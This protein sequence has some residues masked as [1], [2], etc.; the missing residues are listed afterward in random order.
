MKKTE[1]VIN[2]NFEQPWKKIV[3]LFKS[4]FRT[5]SNIC[6]AAFLG[7]ELTVKS[8]QLFSKKS[9]IGD[10]RLGSTYT[11]SVNHQRTFRESGPRTCRKSGPY[12][13]IHC[14]GQK[15]LDD[16][17]EVA[18]FKYDNNLLNLKPKI[19]PTRHFWFQIW[20]FFVFHKTLLN[21]I[22]KGAEYACVC[23]THYVP[24]YLNLPK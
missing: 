3:I 23:V 8:C 1:K 2:F 10:F 5:Q 20:N 7:K 22:Y 18:D 15:H 6:N 17:L 19:T 24:I 4:V 21:D 13:K 9:S 11:S 14:I 12:A 16:K